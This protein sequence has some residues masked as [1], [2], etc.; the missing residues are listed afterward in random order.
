MNPI[1]FASLLVAGV[2][3]VAGLLIAIF[4]KVMAVEVDELAKEINE[5]LPGAN[6]GACGYSGCMGYASAL[7]KGETKDTAL[8]SPGGNEVSQAIAK[9][10]GLAAGSVLPTAAVVLC[11]G[12]EENTGR[13]MFYEGVVSCK[14]AQQ[15][16]GGP[17][18]CIYGC[19]GF[20]DCVEACPYDA[21]HICGG[22]A[23][24]NP[25]ACRACKKCV[26]VCPKK[27][28]EMIPLH[29]PRAAVLC[30][31]KEKGSVTR[32]E[33]KVGCIGCM[34]CK[35]VCEDDAV[36]I[37]SNVAK[38]DYDKCTGCGKCKEV[39]PVHCIDIMILGQTRQMA[40]GE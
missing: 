29:T 19:I 33:C 9:R 32:K 25:L 36:I 30:K 35:K 7:S 12:I 10:L 5:A 40:A 17:K 1:I 23:R 20:G 22:I 13:K 11:Q 15:L 38:I 28:I 14:M 39:C 27:L 21:I 31:N 34:R 37:E 24:I 18:D 16:F 6:C 26:A 8:C 4:S 2:G 3:L